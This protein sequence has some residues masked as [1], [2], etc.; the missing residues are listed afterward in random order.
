[1]ERGRRRS[2]DISLAETSDKMHETHAYQRVYWG[3]A[4]VAFDIDVQMRIESDGARTLD[5]AMRHLRQCCGDAPHLWSAGDLLAQ[6]DTWYGSALFSRTA[7]TVLEAKALPDI[8]ATMARLGVQ[9][10][11]GKVQLDEQSPNAAIRRSIMAPR[12]QPS[13][14]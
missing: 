12:R 4:A 3:G 10:H 11:D 6:L 13:S 7:K 5:E 8:E 1:F 9:V 2:M 14:P